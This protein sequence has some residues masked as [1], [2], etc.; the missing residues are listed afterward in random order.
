MNPRELVDHIRS[1]PAELELSE[2]LRF[3]HQTCSNPC[4]L[5]EF[6]RVLQSSETI[7]TVSCQPH[8]ILQLGIDEWVLLVKSIG[9][10]KCIGALTLWFDSHNLHAFQAVADAVNSAHSLHTLQL[11]FV[12][13]S[14]TFP[15]DLSGLT[16]L[17]NALGEHTGLRNFTWID[18]STQR[19]VVQIPAL[20][21]IFRILPAC[22]HL[23][24]VTIK[25]KFASAGTLQNLL[26]LQLQHGTQLSLVVIRDYWMVATDAIRQ[27]NCNVQSLCL[28]LW[29]EGPD[30]ANEAVQA[31]ASA[32]RLD[33]NL[34]SLCLTMG[35]HFTDEA[36]VAL[37]KALAVNTTLLLVLLIFKRV[38]ASA[39]PNTAA[40]GV[41]VYEA[42]SAM[43]RVNTSLELQ[44]RLSEIDGASERVRES[45]DQ[46]RIEQLVNLVGR[47][48]LVAWSQTT[49]EQ[50]ADALQELTSRNVDESPAFQ[51]SC[52]YSVLR[53]NPTVVRMS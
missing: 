16:A 38:D 31:V 24:N 28:Y 40:F 20:D 1:G 29:E 26:L 8:F 42:L 39:L 3:N 49:R 5:N 10:I 30:E 32:I 25:T 46:M 41:P 14:E 22:P 36:G 23:R 34:K 2:P 12:V 19:E 47:G 18:S 44:V 11:I 21:H 13:R 50:W 48:K 37:A 7:R 6:L 4:D 43:L 52:V 33:R 15:R 51:V 9:R 45:R 53:S 27:G 17:V 35:D